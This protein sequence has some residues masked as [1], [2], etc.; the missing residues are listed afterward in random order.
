MTMMA[1]DV[2]VPG[3][4]QGTGDVL[5][6]ENTTDN[7]LATFRFKNVATK[8]EAAEEDFDLDGHHLRAGAFVIRDGNDAKVRAS[9]QELG[10]TAYATSATTVKT[11][12]LTVPRIGYVH[13]WQRTQDEG[14]VRAA[15]DHYGVPYTYF[16]DQKLREGNLRAKYDVIVFPS[17]GGSSVSQV[18]GIPK[19]G[20]DPIPYKKTKLTPNLGVEDSSDDIRGGMGIEGLAELV[21][22]V[23]AGGTLITEGSTTTILPDYGITTQVNVEH[24]TILYAKGAL[25][26]GIIADKKSPI[27]YGY[28]GDQMPVYFSQD[29]VLNTRG[30]GIRGAAAVPGVGA[31]ITPNATPIALSPYDFD[32]SVA[33][34][35][36]LP[37]QNSDAEAARQAIRQFGGMEDTSPA[38]RVVLRFPAKA[39]EIL[40]SGELAGGQALTN[41]ALALDQPIGQ[42]HVVMFALRPFW[43]W[44]TQGTYALGFNTIL[45]W[46]HLGAG[47]DADKD[48]VKKDTKPQAASAN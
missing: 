27:V 13:S 47:F 22:F 23:Q 11:H 7:V 18:N 21:K 28:T 36:G 32:D 30:A 48:A 6:V 14:W 3:V 25:M 19:T 29:P 33:E 17:I 26:R 9:I 15:L 43:R 39:D 12:P 16:A 10:L 34:P 37:S 38:P 45:N 41:H 40:L 35:K 2:V 5:I 20:P 24:P 8:M 42:G 31:D 44:Q 46:D 1:K 4:I